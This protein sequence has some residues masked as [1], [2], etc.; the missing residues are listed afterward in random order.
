MVKLS[1]LILEPFSEIRKTI[2]SYHSDTDERDSN[3]HVQASTLYRSQ[4]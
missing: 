2:V 3:W 4:N 1:Q